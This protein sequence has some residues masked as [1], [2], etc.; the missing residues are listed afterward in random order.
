MSES[1]KQIRAYILGSCGNCGELTDHVVGLF[2]EMIK[3]GEATI[4]DFRRLSS[5]R[6]V[7][8]IVESGL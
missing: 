8:R 5:H 7:E 1:E 6:V 2:S 4:E 3:N